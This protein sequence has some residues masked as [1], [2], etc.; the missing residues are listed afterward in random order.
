MLPKY[1]NNI[2]V[3]L[4]CLPITFYFCRL[5]NDDKSAFSKQLLHRPGVLDYT[6]FDFHNHHL[7]DEQ[8]KFIV[9][10]LQKKVRELT[11]S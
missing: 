6:K 4:E 8:K 3:I 10:Y 1:Y 11:G 7:T 2:N 5:I 9:L